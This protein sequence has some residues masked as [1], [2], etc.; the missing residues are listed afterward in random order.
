M[1]VKKVTFLENQQVNS[2]TIARIA[3]IR[4][5]SNNDKPKTIAKP[6][7]HSAVA[8]RQMVEKN[9]GK[10]FTEQFYD[11]KIY[12]NIMKLKYRGK[13][14][15]LVVP[16]FDRSKSL[17]GIDIINRSPKIKKFS[18][19]QLGPTRTILIPEKVVSS[20]QKI[21]ARHK[22]LY[23]RKNNDFFQENNFKPNFDL[24]QVAKQLA[25]DNFN[26]VKE[27]ALKFNKKVRDV[28]ESNSD[29][30]V[31]ENYFELSNEENLKAKVQKKL[32]NIKNKI[33]Y[34]D[35]GIENSEKQNRIGWVEKILAEADESDQVDLS[36][37]PEL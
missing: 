11:S 21:L 23:S 19:D 3:G 29:L 12:S 35:T 7:V 37:R 18:K 30:E 20:E 8:K 25:E 33:N 36:K 2:R 10:S 14:F 22:E 1:K 13:E 17:L 28:L 9:N 15:K 5:S 6:T 31:S 24:N 27:R 4:I 34:Q 26:S 16:V 32:L